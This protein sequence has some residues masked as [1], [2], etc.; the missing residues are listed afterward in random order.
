M[1]VAEA[2]IIKSFGRIYISC[3]LY[4]SKLFRLVPAQDKSYKRDFIYKVIWYFHCIIIVFL[5]NNSICKRLP[6]SVPGYMD[7]Y[8]SHLQ[9]IFRKIQTL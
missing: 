6:L 7:F 5:C 9:R 1:A 2:C 3:N 4:Y 8:M